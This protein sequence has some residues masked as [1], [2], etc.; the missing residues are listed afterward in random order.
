ML[1]GACDATTI[2]A[3]TAIGVDV[4][5]GADANMVVAEFIVMRLSLEVSLR[6]C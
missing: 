3:V 1:P 4:L 6:F 5:D 2:A